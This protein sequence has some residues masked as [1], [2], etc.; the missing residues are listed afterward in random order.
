MSDRQDNP[1]LFLSTSA[2]WELDDE[3]YAD[4]VFTRHVVDIYRYPEGWDD[5]PTQDS[6]D[7]SEPLTSSSPQQVGQLSLGIFDDVHDGNV[8][9]ALD[10]VSQPFAELSPPFTHETIDL[11]APLREATWSVA[12][13]EWFSLDPT[14]DT[15]EIRARILTSAMARLT[16]HCEVILARTGDVGI[17]PAASPPLRTPLSGLLG[18][19]GFIYLGRD[20]V[21]AGINTPAGDAY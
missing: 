1:D 17:P 2:R 20:I 7:A 9:L 11:I 4:F 6:G 16:R 19:E 18:Q 3:E 8:L 5:S 15:P 12:G 13:V 14:C 21:G 10:E